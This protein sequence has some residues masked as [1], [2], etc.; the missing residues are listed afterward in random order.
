MGIGSANPDSTRVVAGNTMDSVVDS[1]GPARS[2]GT[3]DVSIAASYA[4]VVDSLPLTP[5]G[6]GGDSIFSGES[7]NDFVDSSFARGHGCGL[8]RRR[9]C[10]RASR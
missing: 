4:T 7:P 1:S 9:N 10:R 8:R 3:K 2:L 6:I 5:L